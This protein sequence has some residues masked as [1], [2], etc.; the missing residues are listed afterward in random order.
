MHV[1]LHYHSNREAAI[2]AADL[3]DPTAM[4]QLWHHMIEQFRRVGVLVAG[5]DTGVGSPI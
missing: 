5:T 3:V 4:T 2:F 1:A